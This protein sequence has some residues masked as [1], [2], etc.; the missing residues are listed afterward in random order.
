MPEGTYPIVEAT[1]Y[2]ATAPKSNSA[3]SYYRALKQVEEEGKIQVPQHLQ[4]ATRDGRALGHGKGYKYP[5][6]FEGHFTPQNYLPDAIKGM[7]FYQ[8]GNQGY[9]V[10]AAERLARWRSAQLKALG[11]EPKEGPQLTR[12]QEEI[13]KRGRKPVNS[14]Q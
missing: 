10:Q 11:L 8:P 2:L 14:G 3:G 6:E 7:T 12:E 5:H 13:M 1:L 9:E 4:D